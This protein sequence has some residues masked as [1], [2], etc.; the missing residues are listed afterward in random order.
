MSIAQLEDTTIRHILEG[1]KTRVKFEIEQGFIDITKDGKLKVLNDVESE[2]GNSI[3]TS[4]GE[5]QEGLMTERSLALLQNQFKTAYSNHSNRVLVLTSAKQYMPASGKKYPAAY[6]YIVE[7]QNALQNLSSQ[8]SALLSQPGLY[9][10]FVQY[11]KNTYIKNTP[12]TREVFSDGTV[13]YRYPNL[14]LIIQDPDP[15]KNAIIVTGTGDKTIGHAEFNKLFYDFLRTKSSNKA[16]TEFIEANTDAGH[17]L[18]VFNIKFATLFDLKV[19]QNSRTDVTDITTS[20]PYSST[21][22]KVQAELN[23]LNGAFKDAMVLL[24]QADVISSNLFSNA[25]LVATTVKHVLDNVGE[26]SSV[27]LQLAVLNR[28]AGSQL[29]QLGVKLKKLGVTAANASLRPVPGTTSQVANVADFKKELTGIFNDISKMGNYIN[30][31]VKGLYSNKKILTKIEKET[32]REL[33]KK[34][35]SIGKALV[36]S[37]G[38]LSMVQAIEARMANELRIDGKVRLSPQTSKVSPKISLGSKSKKSPLSIKPI[39]LL[40]KSKSIK[41]PTTV[42]VPGFRPTPKGRASSVNLPSLLNRINGLIQ[43]QVQRNM[44][45]GSSRNVLNYRTG[46]FAESVKVERLSESRQGMITAF[47][48]YMKNPY[49]TFSQGGRQQYPRSRDPK[50]LISKSIREIA[51]TMVTN[52]LRAVNV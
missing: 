17:I 6:K 42:K 29:S 8:A 19:V 46:R 7:N 18:G 40:G 34:S 28:L 39:S 41:A 15:A 50:T 13:G 47:Y 32:I 21:D 35:K 5:T 10:D 14:G 49:A 43:Q 24:S 9:K 30:E 1:L 36:T 23:F 26:R 27:E 45:T 44:G 22:S 52:Q 12:G 4:T 3:R 2:F 31:V 16:L 11:F 20:L 25:S 37:A 51:Q 48:S 33:R 38:S